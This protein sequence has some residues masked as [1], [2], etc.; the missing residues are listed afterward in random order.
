M[1]RSVPFR[2]RGA[3]WRLTIT[4]SYQGTC[5]FI[6]FCNGPS[7]QVIKLPGG[8]TADSFGLGTGTDKHRLE[9]SGPGVYQVVVKAGSDSAKW[10]I[11]VED[12]Y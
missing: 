10:R 12:R 7:A 11:A 8:Q 2:I 3:H 5:T 4:M 9:T 1:R 6:F